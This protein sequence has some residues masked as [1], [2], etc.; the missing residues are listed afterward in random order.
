MIQIL[1]LV[2][3][4]VGDQILFFPTLEDLKTA[5][6]Q[7][8]IDVVVEPRATGAYRLCK[9]VRRVIPFDY[10]ANNSLAD[11]SNILGVI[12]E[13]EYDLALSL[14][15]RWGV[16]FFLWLTGIPVRVGYGRGRGLLTQTVPLK[17][18][19][20]A[21]HMYHDLLGGLGIHTPCPSLQ[22]TVPQ[23][24]LDWAEAEKGRLEV[25]GYLLVHGGASYLSR[26]LGIDKIYPPRNWQV[27]IQDF[28]KRQPQISPVLI[29]GPEDQEL[30]KTL[31][32]IC[33]GVKVTAPPDLGKLAAI[34]AGANLLLCTDSAPMHLG[35]AVRTYTFALFGPTDPQRL[36]P[37]DPRF[38][39]IKSPTGRMADLDPQQVLTKVWGG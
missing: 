6:P 20:Y 2:P 13:Q 14:G 39:G 8:Q 31:Q 3:G 23:A 5:Y 35:V 9:H 21:A 28:Q 17:A 7:A 25:S 33:P 22:V 10:K 27:I 24:D 16:R 29:E 34:I 32:E 1:V 18:E 36:L 37:P 30:V 26:A 15:R 11:W 12:R 4:G 38:V 19:Q